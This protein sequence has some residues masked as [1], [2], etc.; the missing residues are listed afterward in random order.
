MGEEIRRED[1]S[2][3]ISDDVKRQLQQGLKRRTLLIGL[4][5]L[6]AGGA[7]LALLLFAATKFLFSVETIECAEIGYYTVEEII[8]ASG[9]EEGKPIFLISKE[10]VRRSALEKMPF[11]ADLKVELSYPDTV[12]LTPV[13]EKPCFYFEA[14]IPENEFVVVSESQKV[15]T[16]FDEEEQLLADFPEVYKVKMPVLLF[17]VSGQKLQ[18]S[19]RGDGDYI[20]ELL[21]HLKNSDFSE[22]ILYLDAENRFELTVYCQKN[23]RYDYRIYLG[24]KKNL[25]EKILFAQGIRARVAE[26]FQGLIGV[27]D[28][29][30]GYADPDNP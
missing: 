11:L 10:D 17:I 27:E 8:E 30:K 14:D 19:E 15:L 28:P 5:C 22:E 4:T 7:I 12:V 29:T 24:N 26:S 23:G 16:M 18:F 13:E 1:G 6:V 21:N 20:P 9:I 3:L 25:S 2:V